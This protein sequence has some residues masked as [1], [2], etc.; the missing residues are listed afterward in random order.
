MTS[1]K[2]PD[3]Q[4]ESHRR[5]PASADLDAFNAMVRAANAEVQRLQAIVEQTN[6]LASVV[7]EMVEQLRAPLQ[8]YEEM[9]AAT[10]AAIEQDRQLQAATQAANVHR[11]LV[12]DLLTN[13]FTFVERES[14]QTL[15]QHGWFPDQDLTIPE[16]EWLADLFAEDAE[17]ARLV[18]CDRFRELLNDIETKV[19]SAFPNRSEI[20]REAFHAHEQGQ[21][22]LSVLGFLTQIDGF[23]HDL[24]DKSLFITRDRV[25]VDSHIGQMHNQLAREMARVLLDSDWP[26]IMT[27]GTRPDDFTGLNR[28]Q[29]LHGEVTDFGTEENSLKAI[30]LLNYCAF[31]LPRPEQGPAKANGSE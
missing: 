1:D 7:D 23:F 16:I 21:Y 30:S 20:L 19:K 14:V 10:Q 12:A 27:R 24:W 11:R 29:V 31:V 13:L 3:G 28:H 15:M 18:L 17:M 9:E 6:T 25:D 2:E 8:L 22:Y 5:D 26:L 4:P